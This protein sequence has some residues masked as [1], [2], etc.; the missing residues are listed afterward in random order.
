MIGKS[1]IQEQK[2]IFQPLLKEFIDMNHELVLLS[3]EINWKE[4]EEEF[5]S[6]Y[7][8]TGTPGKPIRLMCGL[9]I[10]KQLYDLGDE[11]LIPAWISNPY[12]QH[13][14]G[15][16][17]FQWRQ[18]CDPSDLVHFRKRIGSTG[19][20]KIFAQSIRI[21]GK[22]GMNDKLNIDSTVHEKNITFPT[23]TKLRKKIIDK[24]VAI[25][26]KENIELRQSYK[27]TTK[28]CLIKS[29]FA[30]HPKRKKQARAAQRKIKT[31][32][33]RLVR[34]LY[35]KLPVEKL[36][37]YENEL[38]LFARV[39]AQQQNDS[40]KIYSLHEP[41]VSCIAKGKVHTPYEF[42][43]KASIATTQ[44]GNII[45]AAVSFQGNPHDSKTLDKTLEQHQRLT[46]VKALSAN[47]DRGY[48]GSKK[49]NGTQI[50]APDAGKNHTPYQK[51]KM[52]NRFR[53]RAAIEPVISHMKHQ[54]RMLKNYLK[55]VAGDAINL[56]MSAAA[57]N[58]K[59]YINKIRRKFY[60][61]FFQTRLQISLFCLNWFIGVDLRVVKD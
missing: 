54:Y 28:K 30:H 31:I 49:V 13:F 47:V 26:K 11:T 27:F 45:V 4:L 17:H 29:R 52:R 36:S 43:S 16:A 19:I 24:C 9:L 55:G 48:T 21:H 25:A 41:N 10:L 39:L 2:N 37:H 23:D 61:V 40:N 50:I 38:Q 51:Q 44:N 12:M 46:T 32:A 34:E 22:Q 33:A 6:L 14:C 5:S 58:F 1:P 20:E 60:F 42:G 57:F 7:S 59:S 35:R 15:E 3:Q 53:R 18:P 8:N 56:M